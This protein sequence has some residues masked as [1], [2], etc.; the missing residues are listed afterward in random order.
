M[1][2]SDTIDTERNKDF[3][4]AYQDAYDELPTVYAVQAYDAAAALDAAI[5]GAETTDGAGIAAALADIGEID[6]PRGAW[7]FDA[8]HNPDQ[9]YYLREV[10]KSGSGFGNV[11]ISDLTE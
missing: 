7:S 2:Y 4:A 10:Q 6:S 5:D 8:D 9:P 3:V 11:V 1:H